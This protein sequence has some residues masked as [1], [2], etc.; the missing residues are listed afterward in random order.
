MIEHEWPQNWPELFDQ[1]DQLS[2]TSTI[3]AQLPFIILQRLIEDVITMGTVENVSRR[4]E[5]NNAI[6]LRLSALFQLILYNLWIVSMINV[7]NEY[8]L[9]YFQADS[10]LLARC[11]I[12]LLSEIVEWVSA[13]VLEPFLNDILKVICEYLKKPQLSIYE[14]AARC[15]W[16]LSSRRR[17]KNDENI[18]VVALFGDLPMKTILD[19]AVESAN[20]NAENVE[21]YRYL[22]VICDILS[23]LGTHLCD[24]WQKEPPNFDMFLLAVDAFFQHPSLY[25]RNESSNVLVSFMSDAKICHNQMFSE[26]TSRI[27]IEIPKLIQKI[28]LPSSNDSSSCAYSQIDYDDDM[29]FMHD[30]IQ[31]RDRCIRIIRYACADEKHAPN[32]CKIVED[33][34]RN[35]CISSPQCVSEMEWDA[36]QRYSRTVLSGCHEEK[37]ITEQQMN[38]FTELFDGVLS[39]ISTSTDIT[40]IN[41]LLSV[42]SSL[43]IILTTRPDRLSS[44]LIQVLFQIRR[45]LVD[46]VDDDKTMKRHCL[47]VLLRL[48]TAFSD[49]VKD[50]AESILE[51]C[52]SV[53]NSLSLMQQA[54]CTHLLAA[55]SNLCVDFNV[56]HNFLVSTLHDS[57]AALKSDAQFLSYIGFTSQAPLTNDDAQL[58]LYVSNRRYLRS[59]LSAVEGVLT[60]VRSISP[61]LH[62][63]F[64]II[65]PI[66]P[67][68]FSL[69]ERLNSLHRPQ[70]VNQIHHSYGPT[71]IE[72]TDSDRQQLISAIDP[73][74]VCSSRISTEDPR[75]H[76]RCFISDITDSIQSITGLLASKMANELFAELSLHSWLLQ[77]VS[78]ID[79]VPDFRIRFW[80]KRSWRPISN[81]CPESAYNKIRAMFIKILS[82]IQT[83]LQARWEQLA[84]VEIC[85]EPSLEQ[86]Y[87]EHM[88]CV[89]T[90]ECVNLLRSILNISDSSSSAPSSNRSFHHSTVYIYDDK[91]EDPICFVTAQ[92]GQ[93]KE[94]VEMMVALSFS[95]LTCRDTTSS[96]RI[97]PVCKA[98]VDFIKN[99]VIITFHKLYSLFIHSSSLISV[100]SN[101]L[102]LCFYSFSFF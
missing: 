81:C 91:K 97:A 96:I 83:R 63:A 41:R 73:L 59:H 28:G 33:W 6:S 46:V 94:A 87:N 20:V 85:E 72:I 93:D 79:V 29:Q 45:L 51:L 61:P 9:R 2:S 71:V 58:S 77:L 4:R 17:A 13:K 102:K 80:I 19:S 50:Q 52:L 25:L 76:A 98:L 65:Q 7:N 95:C 11:A 78:H 23:A 1:L 64:S 48:I 84:H 30:F 99:M 32:L 40:L 22:K 56:Q 92:I 101:H 10:V 90:R 66:L 57:I 21:H 38:V 43:F 42:V 69:V 62:P 44:F 75:D 67:I 16:R 86:L 39:Q 36:M 26:L 31:F 27:I 3:H 5:L 12:C 24:V 68:I 60:Q 53:R 35:R 14:F 89:L 55:L 37:H 100:V 88:V 18:I 82:E 15:L 70:T 74:S 34:I 8:K 47:S 54:T 49:A